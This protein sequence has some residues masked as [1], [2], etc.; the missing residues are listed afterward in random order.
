MPIFQVNNLSYYYPESEK[1]A[2]KGINI[3]VEE[4]EFLLVV[5]GSGSGKSTL[6]RTLAGLV[7]DFYGGVFSGKVLFKGQDIRRMDRRKLSRHVGMVFQD[8]EKQLVK[9]EA[10]AE[11]AFGL[12]NLGLPQQEMLRRVAEVMDFLNLEEA[13]GRFID[14]LSGG[15]K[16]KIAL[17]SVLAMQPEAIILDEPTSQLDPTCA[18]DFLNLIKRLNEEMG[19]TVVLIEQRLERCFHLADRVAVMKDGEIIIQGTPQEVASGSIDSGIPFIPPVAR[20]FAGAGFSNIPVTVKEGR[21]ILKNYLP[22]QNNDAD[23]ITQTGFDNNKERKNGETIALKKVWFSYDDKK[24]V[25]RGIDLQIFPGEF[26]AILGANGAGKSTLL[27]VMAGL[28]YPNR[29]KIMF[30]GKA[31]GK[32]LEVYRQGKVAYLS[33]NPNDYLFQDTVEQ[34]LFFTLKNFDKPDEG[35]VDNLLEKLDLNRHKHRN[36]RDLSSGERQRV[37]LASVLVTEPELVLLDEPT[38]GMDYAL[39]AD[40]GGYLAD[41]CKG[42]VSVAVVTHDV[43]FAA[44]YA[45]RVIILYD[46]RIVSDGNAKQILGSSMFYSTQMARMCKGFAEDILTVEEALD[47]LGPIIFRAGAN[48]AERGMG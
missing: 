22:L 32:N 11:I 41:L 8:P 1:P 45:E 13:K 48:A 17:A 34:E 33:Q 39:K 10:E 30:R 24:E 19:K 47:I 2:L 43:E 12:E 4:G 25:L 7:P 9:T 6:A 44:E 16:Q 3:T 15:Q 29:G 21:S 5:G 40:L 42:G 31:C 35:R 14:K 36:P 18:E 28:L 46:G 23:S 27:K 20:F 26:V 37:A 38:R